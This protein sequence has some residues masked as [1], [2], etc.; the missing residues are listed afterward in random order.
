MRVI[1]YH[2][3]V[4]T[5]S[6]MFVAALFA[7]RKLNDR[8]RDRFQ[9]GRYHLVMVMA[10]LALSLSQWTMWLDFNRFR[11]LPHHETLV[12]ALQVVPKDASVLVPRRMLGHVSQRAKWDVNGLFWDQIRKA[13]PREIAPD[14]AYSFDYVIFDA[15]ERQYPPFFTRE[16]FE[17]FQKNP[18]YRVVFGENNVF[19]FQRVLPAT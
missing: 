6:A 13:E 10:L 1:A 9:G 8:L 18:A 19:V 5:S 7:I 4:A 14:Y 3:H 12:R 11:K 17:Q 2:Y 15:N 16:V